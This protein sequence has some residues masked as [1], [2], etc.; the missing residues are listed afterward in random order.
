M[1]C[2]SCFAVLALSLAPM[3]AWPHTDVVNAGRSLVPTP[4]AGPT[5][6]T[7]SGSLWMCWLDGAPLQNLPLPT[8]KAVVRVA[9][10]GQVFAA[11]T[12]EV[13]P[14]GTEWLRLKSTTS[15]DPVWVPLAY[16]QRVS[17]DNAMSGDLPIGDER[18]GPYDGLTADYR[19]S[20]LV[21]VAQCYCF[22]DEPQRLRAEAAQACI[23]MLEAAQ[24][25]AGLT[26]KI[27]SAYRS[28][29]TQAYLCRR[30]IES[31][32]IEQRAVARP[33]HS[34]HQLGTTVDLVGD[35]GRHLLTERFN[36]TREG[37]WLRFNC[38][39][40]GFVQTY[41][42]QRA[43]RDGIAYEPWH[44]RYVGRTNVQRFRKDNDE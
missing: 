26:I 21:R 7:K 17:P 32:G 19:P 39:R 5:S 23:R 27:L 36:W 8:P 12:V 29:Q 16:C 41:S 38:G 18:L 25:E 9:H 15:G 44:F 28:A 37:Q 13:T 35:N 30:K 43:Q 14:F 4:S 2:K 11:E 42:R 22:N 24:R 31:E 34:E 20:D 33:G 6:S 3:A 10:A 1:G 40:F